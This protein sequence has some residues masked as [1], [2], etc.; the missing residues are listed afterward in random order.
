MYFQVDKETQL[1][2]LGTVRATTYTTMA[3]SH[4]M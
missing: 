3:E 4:G 1:A 2:V